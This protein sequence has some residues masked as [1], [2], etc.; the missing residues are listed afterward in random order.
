ML[1]CVT[2][3]STAPG[4]QAGSGRPPTLVQPD[5]FVRGAG[6]HWATEDGAAVAGGATGA[7]SVLAAAGEACAAVGTSAA[8]STPRARRG[9][10]ARPA[11]TPSRQRPSH[12]DGT[13]DECTVDERWVGDMDIRAVAD[14][15]VHTVRQVAKPREAALAQRKNTYFLAGTRRR[16]RS[17]QWSTRATFFATCPRYR[18]S[19]RLHASSIHRLGPSVFSHQLVGHQPRSQVVFA[20]S[21]WWHGGRRGAVL[22]VNVGELTQLSIPIHARRF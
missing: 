19:G 18:A 3:G 8:R 16:A 15:F 2:R 14:R 9:P 20:S 10:Q 21:V 1:F 5:A 4:V 17:R 7:A 13:L 11:Q 12:C 6:A 22:G